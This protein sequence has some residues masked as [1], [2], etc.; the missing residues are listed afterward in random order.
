MAKLCIR[1]IRTHC[2]HCE[3]SNVSTQN[4]CW[5]CKANLLGACASH[6]PNACN[7]ASN[8]ESSSNTRTLL[9]LA[10]INE[11][12]LVAVPL[13]HRYDYPAVPLLLQLTPTNQPAALDVH[14]YNASPAE[15]IAPPELHH[16]VL[17]VLQQGGKKPAAHAE[18]CVALA[19]DLKRHY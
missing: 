11:P 10:I 13:A 6:H 3:N 14:H 12:L 9:C 8:S 7:S 5:L 4:G 19:Q 16:L 1:G 15:L 2:S 18:L 17:I